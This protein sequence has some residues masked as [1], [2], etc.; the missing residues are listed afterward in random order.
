MIF[1]PIALSSIMTLSRRTWIGNFAFSTLKLI[2]VFGFFLSAIQSASY[3][4]VNSG[5]S[6]EIFVPLGALKVSRGIW[7]VYEPVGLLF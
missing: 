4:S 3:F 6:M 5:G 1:Y 2:F 7:M